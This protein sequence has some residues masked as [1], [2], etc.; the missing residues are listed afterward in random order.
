MINSDIGKSI[1]LRAKQKMS[2]LNSD[3]SSY[4]VFGK[5]LVILGWGLEVILHCQETK[6]LRIKKK[7]IPSNKINADLN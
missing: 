4:D 6:C 5:V 7:F 1:D 3:K 2:G